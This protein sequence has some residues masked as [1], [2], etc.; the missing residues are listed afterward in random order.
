MHWERAARGGIKVTHPYAIEELPEGAFV[1]LEGVAYLYWNGKLKQ[2]SP[3]GYIGD[4]S[5]SEK[6]VVTLLTPPS[7]VEMMKMGFIPQVHDSAS[8]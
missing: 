8:K 5:M 6:G 7:I 1:E 4:V 3:G 2:W